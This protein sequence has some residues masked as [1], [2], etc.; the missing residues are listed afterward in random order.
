MLS[1]ATATAPPVTDYSAGN[2]TAIEN[3]AQGIKDDTGPEKFSR[4]ENSMLSPDVIV[5]P[6]KCPTG[7]GPFPEDC[8][9]SEPQ[10]G[11]G[12][13][14]AGECCGESGSALSSGD[15]PGRV[16]TGCGG[17]PVRPASATGPSFEPNRS[18]T[19]CTGVPAPS[20]SP[21]CD[22]TGLPR[23]QISAV[24]R[25]AT[26]DAQAR[27]DGAPSGKVS[28]RYKTARNFCKLLNFGFQE[29]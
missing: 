10:I 25:A 7:S 5:P 12:D 19:V 22:P 3:R 16:P 17:A 21:A 29:S 20:G 13:G 1:G 24:S 26:A 23:G 4:R 15:R 9:R 27:T 2:G 28:F 6:C 8:E 11:Y 18:R 14:K